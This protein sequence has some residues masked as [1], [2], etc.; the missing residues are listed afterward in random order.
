[1]SYVLAKRKSKFV[2]TLDFF[3]SQDCFLLEPA[4]VLCMHHTLNI[5][6]A[7]FGAALHISRETCCSS[8]ESDNMQHSTNKEG[9][10]RGAELLLLAESEGKK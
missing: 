6:Q 4:F 9:T 3:Y 2:A 8:W 10:C 5:A 7:E 1:M